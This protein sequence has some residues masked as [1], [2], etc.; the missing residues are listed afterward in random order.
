MARSWASLSML[1]W[2]VNIRNTPITQIENGQ[3]NGSLLTLCVASLFQQEKRSAVEEF[4]PDASSLGHQATVKGRFAGLAAGH[5]ELL[6]LAF[7]N[8]LLR[9]FFK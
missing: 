2:K 8:R 6:G 5:P 3:L 7:S 9:P 4:A 1:K